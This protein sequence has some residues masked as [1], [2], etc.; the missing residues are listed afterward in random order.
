MLLQLFLQKSLVCFILL[1]HLPHV[2][3]TNHVHILNIALMMISLVLDC[4]KIVGFDGLSLLDALDSLLLIFLFLHSDLPL[5]ILDVSRIL[6]FLI[7]THAPLLDYV[8]IQR[9]S[10]LIGSNLKASLRNLSF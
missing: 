3:D 9:L 4:L 8:L 6:H 7:K 5:N 10:K 2:L 1:S